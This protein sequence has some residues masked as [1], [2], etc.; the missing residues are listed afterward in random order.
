MLLYICLE[1]KAYIGYIVDRPI[2]IYLFKN[3]TFRI[4]SLKIKFFSQNFITLRPIH[5]YNTNTAICINEVEHESF[6]TIYI[7]N[8]TQNK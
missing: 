1:L 2:I 6:Y 3:R 7:E 8:K 5:L 4:F